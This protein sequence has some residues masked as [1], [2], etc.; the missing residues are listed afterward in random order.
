MQGIKQ[1]L[2]FDVNFRH[3]TLVVNTLY[4]P[5]QLIHLAEAEETE[6]YVPT[7]LLYHA[8]EHGVIL[9]NSIQAHIS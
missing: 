3:D 9:S 8:L 2:I 5:R 7:A 4:N 1:D 6:F